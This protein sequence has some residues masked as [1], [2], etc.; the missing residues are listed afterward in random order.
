M[1]DT[2]R[3]K[4]LRKQLVEEL[5]SK[6][7]TDPSVL[8]A[9]ACVPR[10]Y[11]VPTSLFEHAYSDRALPILCKQ[12]ISQPYTVA[13]QTEWMEIKKNLRVLEIGTGS[14]YQAA[15]LRHMGAYVYTIERQRALY[16]ST[17]RLFHE[18]SLAIATKYG[19]GYNGWGEFAPF[20]RILLTCGAAEIPQVLL[21]QLKLNGILVAPIGE[22]EQIMTKAVRVSATAVEVSTHGAYRFVPMVK[23][24]E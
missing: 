3:T 22:T 15:I 5:K 13:R 9:M 10:H 6:G 12:T 4:G 14:G 19:D 16:E 23:N 2:Y 8:D 11:F 17:K 20:D 1:T 18:L 24:T 7:I 21:N